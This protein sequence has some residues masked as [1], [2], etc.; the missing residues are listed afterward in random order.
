MSS[1]A[2]FDLNIR[3]VNDAELLDSAQNLDQEVC[4]FRRVIVRDYGN[5]AGDAVH[6]I[7]L[8]DLLDAV[9]FHNLVEH[10]VRRVGTQVLWPILTCVRFL[11]A[12]NF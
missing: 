1:N 4:Y 6:V 12:R 8:L 11:F 10:P 7:V 2:A 5:S 3:E 9:S